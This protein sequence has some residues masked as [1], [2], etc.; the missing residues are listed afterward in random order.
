MAYVPAAMKSVLAR[1]QA[2]SMAIW[3]RHCVHRRGAVVV[4]QLA[5]LLGDR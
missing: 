3:G 2:R 1:W 4:S 5:A